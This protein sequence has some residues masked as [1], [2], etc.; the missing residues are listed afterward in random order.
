ML[1]CQRLQKSW[2]REVEVAGAEGAG[3]EVAGA[4]GAGVEVVGAEEAGVEVAGAEVVAADR[5]VSRSEG[6]WCANAEM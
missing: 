4:E 2:A 3:V 5:R 1:L 6:T